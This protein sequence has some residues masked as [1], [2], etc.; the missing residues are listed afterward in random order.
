[1]SKAQNIFDNPE[2]FE[3]YRWLRLR[4]QNMNTL[5]EKPALFALAPDLRGK[6][7]LD[8]GCGYGENCAEFLKMGA[9]RVVGTDISE[10]MLAVAQAETTG[11]EYIRADLNDLSAI[12]ER[13]DVIFSS[14]ALHY[15]E[16]L[17]KLCRQVAAL[18]IPGGCF[19]FSQ[20]SPLNTA[21]CEDKEIPRWT[22]NPDGRKIYYNLLD[23]DKVGQKSEK[24]LVDGI[25]KFHRRYCDVVNAVVG[26]GL[27]IERMEEPTV[28]HDDGEGDHFPYFLF[29]KAKLAGEKI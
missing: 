2:F 23:Y 17:D 26:A 20:E 15:V 22:K 28:S 16:G 29:I 6:T 1:M 5:L 19:I 14:L 12:T 25:I 24:W 4:P 13:F 18:L 11:I 27:R 9:S 8:L 21:R 7:V 10:K 3:G